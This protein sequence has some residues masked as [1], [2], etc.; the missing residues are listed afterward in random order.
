MLTYFFYVFYVTRFPLCLFLIDKMAFEVKAGSSKRKFQ[1]LFMRRTDKRPKIRITNYDKYDRGEALET[2]LDASYFRLALDKEDEMQK[3]ESDP[4]TTQFLIANDSSYG[5]T[6]DEA[7]KTFVTRK[8]GLSNVDFRGQN[9]YQPR[10]F[11]ENPNSQALFFQ[12]HYNFDEKNPRARE[13]G[14]LGKRIGNYNGMFNNRRFR[15]KVEKEKKKIVREVYGKKK[16]DDDNDELDN[17]DDRISGDSECNIIPTFKTARDGTLNQVSEGTYDLKGLWK[18]GVRDESPMAQSSDDDNDSDDEERKEANTTPNQNYSNIESV[19][20][21]ENGLALDKREEHE[22]IFANF[23]D[24]VSWLMSAGGYSAYN[25]DAREVFENKVRKLQLDSFPDYDLLQYI[26]T[27]E[28][29]R[30]MEENRITIHTVSWEII[31]RGVETGENFYDF[32]RHQIN[33]S[34]RTIIRYSGPIEGFIKNYLS[35]KIGTDEQYELD[36][37]TFVYYNSSHMTFTASGPEPIYCKHTKTA[38]DDDLLETMNENNWH[39]FLNGCIL[40]TLGGICGREN[41]WLKNITVNLERCIYHYKYAFGKIAHLY[42]RLLERGSIENMIWLF[43]Y[44]NIPT[45]NMKEILEK[46]GLIKLYFRC[47]HK[48]IETR[49]TPLAILEERCQKSTLRVN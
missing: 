30:I 20:N 26:Q 1:L 35:A 43:R 9:E 29:E 34:R 44:L 32:L 21:R 27:R 39:E 22:G 2:F 18:G 5:R 11:R 23:F 45:K 6:M 24:N 42:H 25:H 8:Q 19:V 49:K 15:E 16:G 48:F 7:M 46:L 31:V 38:K 47:V 3:L 13:F 17:N 14:S 10:V 4:L 12:D 28:V 40:S 37:V 33:E 41:Q 36:T